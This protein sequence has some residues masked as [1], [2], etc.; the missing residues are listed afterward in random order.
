M[1]LI[2]LDQGMEDGV[3]DD[4]EGS[5]DGGFIFQPLRDDSMACFSE[6]RG[7]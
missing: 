4:E 7:Q 2:D 5:V 1:E 3:N 6:H